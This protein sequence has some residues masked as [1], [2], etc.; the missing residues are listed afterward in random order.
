M[1][2]VRYND[3][4]S[5]WDGWEQSYGSRIPQVNPRKAGLTEVRSCNSTALRSAI[6]KLLQCLSTNSLAQSSTLQ[7]I[8]IHELLRHSCSRLE[9]LARSREIKLLPSAQLP[10]SEELDK[11]KSGKHKHLHRLRSLV[12]WSLHCALWVWILHTSC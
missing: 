11:S 7:I 9:R 1:F 10:N 5:G 4:W 3:A 6:G 2:A 8:S 12:V